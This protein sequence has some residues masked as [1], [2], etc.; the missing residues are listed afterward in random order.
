MRSPMC[1]EFSRA[2]CRALLLLALLGM[3]SGCGG[4]RP[5]EVYGEF[6]SGG[7]VM[8]DAWPHWSPADSNLIAYTHF[9]VTWEE[10]LEFGDRTVRILDLR[11]L[12]TMH[13]TSGIVC[14]WSPNGGSL[15]VCC[16]DEGYFL[17]D[18]ESGTKEQLPIRGYTPEFSPCGKMIA[19]DSS[20]DPEGTSIYDLET[21]EVKWI[22]S[23][24]EPDWHP[25]GSKLLCY[26]MEV[27]DTSGSYLGTIPYDQQYGYG[28]HARWSPDGSEVT[29]GSYCSTKKKSAGIWTIGAYGTNQRLA[30]CPGAVPTWSPDGR[31]ITYGA[32]S[33][34]RCAMVIWT[35]NADGTNPTQVT[36]PDSG[37]C[38]GL[39]AEYSTPPGS[40]N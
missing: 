13:V 29:Y 10:Y 5:T 1:W 34:D 40:G 16:D 30:A 24:G 9:A 32:R 38:V 6:P 27:Y 39:P 12:E 2:A 11:T 17:M 35:V 36:F 21:G 7:A 25:D 26:I 22:C 8:Q 3:M 28:W 37:L 14:D 19:F 31:K 15:I 23:S 18:L 20:E 4:D 33:D